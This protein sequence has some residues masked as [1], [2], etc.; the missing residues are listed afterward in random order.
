V[1]GQPK[2]ELLAESGTEFF[3]TEVDAQPSFVKDERGEVTGLV[4]HQNGRDIPE[5]LS[6]SS[7]KTAGCRRRLHSAKSSGALLHAAKLFGPALCEI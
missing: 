3:V 2:I 4:L 7:R 5:G 1:P 6:G